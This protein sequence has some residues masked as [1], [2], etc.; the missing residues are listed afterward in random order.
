MRKILPVEE[1]P[2]WIALIIGLIPSFGNLAYPTQM[3]YTAGSK[4][5]ELAEFLMYDISARVGA[6]IPI[7]GG[8]DTETEH[9]F[10]RLPGLILP[11]LKERRNKESVQ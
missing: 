9:F 2:R 6:K 4:S 11:K 7:W 5:I 3:V 1:H 8:K 10:N